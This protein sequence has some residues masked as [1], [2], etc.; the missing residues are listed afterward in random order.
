MSVEDLPLKLSTTYFPYLQHAFPAPQMTHVL[1]WSQVEILFLRG[2]T[3]HSQLDLEHNVSEIMT[4]GLIKCSVNILMG[5]ESKTRLLLARN[6]S[7]AA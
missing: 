2:Q 5:L 4:L 3:I 6:T 7:T 1:R